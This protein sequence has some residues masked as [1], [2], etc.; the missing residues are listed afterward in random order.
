MLKIALIALLFVCAPLL[1][2]Y[3][4]VADFIVHPPKGWERIDDPSQLPQKIRIIYIGKSA[5][6][7][8][9]TPSLNVACEKTNLPIQEY[10]AYAK[11]YH[12]GQSQTV[13]KPLGKVKTEAGV[14]EVLQIDRPSQWGD[15][16]FVQA[17]LI[18]GGEAYVV[19]AT[20]LKEEF[21]GLSVQMFKAIQSLS[22]PKNVASK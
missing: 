18:Q 11:S 2:L 12:E 10:V 7:S 21:S 14:A 16:R 22:I 20:C 1:P 4:D 3:S 6:H 15:I 17:M 8:S 19:T 5:A 13:C 9:F